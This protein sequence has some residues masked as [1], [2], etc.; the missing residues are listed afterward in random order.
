MKIDSQLSELLQSVRE[1]RAELNVLRAEKSLLQQLQNRQALELREAEFAE[2]LLALGAAYFDEIELQSETAKNA[3]PESDGRARA[4]H[5]LTSIDPTLPEAEV[6]PQANAV[7]A[8]SGANV[9]VLAENS[10]KSSSGIDALTDTL[11]AMPPLRKFQQPPDRM[12]DAKPAALTPERLKELQDRMRSS[13]SDDAK[14]RVTTADTLSGAPLKVVRDGLEAMGPTPSNLRGKRPLRREVDRLLEI[15]ART[16]FEWADAGRSGNN[17]L[18]SWLAAR[19]RAAQEAA[20]RAREDDILEDMAPIFHALTAHSGESQPGSIRGLAKHHLPD[21]GDWAAESRA[22]EARVRQLLGEPMPSAEPED[23]FP[24]NFDDD[25]RR[26]TEASRNNLAPDAFVNRVA[27]LIDEGLSAT[28]VRLVN[29]ALPYASELD[30]PRV[31][32]LRRAVEKQLKQTDEDPIE[33]NSPLPPNWPHFHLTRGKR[34]IVVGG[35]PRPERI[36]RLKEVFEFTDVDWLP[37]PTNGTRHLDSLVQ[38]M[39]NGSIDL[40]IVLRAFSS[41]RVSDRVFNCEGANCLR[42]LADT[43]GVNQ[44]RL[45]IERFYG[46]RQAG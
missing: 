5:S 9:G 13:K 3:G 10:A 4:V 40:V 24:E 35:D 41:H 38:R 33:Q 14:V 21:A 31:K 46:E 44:V 12:P 7:L 8:R 30:D 20:T 45:A 42:V 28:D 34:A 25:L 2:A 39:K 17:A 15:S 23:E 43:Y 29:L 1:K 37:D 36:A 18:T 32:S 27:R 16:I 6:A 26:L 11:D 19:A 22:R